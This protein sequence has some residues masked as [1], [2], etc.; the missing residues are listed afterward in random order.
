MTHNFIKRAGLGALTLRILFVSTE[1][2]TGMVLTPSSNFSMPG[3]VSP[4]AASLLNPPH[5]IARASNRSCQ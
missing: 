4:S 3:N 2:L 1:F 5:D